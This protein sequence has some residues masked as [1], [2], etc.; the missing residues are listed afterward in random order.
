MRGLRG[1]MR[2]GKEAPPPQ[3]WGAGLGRGIFSFWHPR[4]GAGGPPVRHLRLALILCLGLCLVGAVRAQT[5]P[6]APVGAV[7]SGPPDV[8]VLIYQRPGLGDQIDVTYKHTVPHAQALADLSALASA[9][10]WPIGASRITDAAPPT[11]GRNGLMTSS[12]FT[13][14]GAIRDD[15]H[16]FPVEAFVTAFR[17][18]RRIGLIFIVGPGFQFQGIGDY[19]DN[20]LRISLDQRGSV[21]NYQIEV[22]NSGFG[23]LDLPRSQPLAGAARPARSP[24]ALLGT[25][26]AAAAAAGI[27]V[28]F[29]TALLARRAK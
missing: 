6:P 23:Q 12:V 13:V 10:G 8:L 19:A 15:T 1:C 7:I 21:F 26:L 27:A 18:Y 14:P 17:S 9:T 22:L 25:V 28:Y 3:S 20:N 29:L 5:P 24:L 11:Q 16:T 2:G 4:V